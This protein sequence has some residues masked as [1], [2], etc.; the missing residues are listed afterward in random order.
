[1]IKL[2]CS[3]ITLR[4]SLLDVVT[5]SSETKVA[6]KQNSHLMCVCVGADQVGQ[7]GGTKSKT[8]PN[9]TTMC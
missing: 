9:E 3:Y 7:M 6:R 8:K 1:M 4:Q 5:K 2:S